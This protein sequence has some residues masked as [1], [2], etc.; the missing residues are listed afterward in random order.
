M[1]LLITYMQ[2]IVCS[3]G[4]LC[5]SVI[6]TLCYLSL[7]EKCSVLSL[8]QCLFRMLAEGHSSLLPAPSVVVH[9]GTKGCSKHP[10]A[11]QAEPCV[12][13][14]HIRTRACF[15]A[16]SAAWEVPAAGQSLDCEVV[17]GS[18]RKGNS[19]LTYRMSYIGSVLGN[20]VCEQSPVFLPDN[21]NNHRR[22]DW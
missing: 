20:P 21:I 17:V 3:Q 19:A 7:Q 1:C 6:C 10:A 8:H 14:Q 15:P 9:S 5:H 18:S 22:W 11:G 4:A 2:M 13:A 12:D 16:S